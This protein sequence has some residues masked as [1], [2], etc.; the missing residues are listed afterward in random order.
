MT[1]AALLVAALA[2]CSN[3]PSEL[4]GTAAQAL[5]QTTHIQIRGKFVESFLNDPSGPN[6]GLTASQDEVAGTAA[7]DFSYAS[8]SPT[9]PNVVILVEGAGAIPSSA[10]TIDPNGASAHL[11]VTTP[12][13][14]ILCQINTSTGVSTCDFTTPSTF[15]ITWA[16]NG[17]ETTSD[18]DTLSTTIGPFTEVSHGTFSRVSASTNGTWDGHTTSPNSQGFMEDSHSTIVTRDITTSS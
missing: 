6:G 18:H 7:L 10:L 12:F 11:A 5:S 17:F 15:D 1:R 2:A 3:A 14:P 4:T 8:L 13:Q 9:D 16:K